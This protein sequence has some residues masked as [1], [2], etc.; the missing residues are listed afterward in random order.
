MRGAESASSRLRSTKSETTSA[1]AATTAS[2]CATSSGSTS[3]RWRSG[4]ASVSRRGMTPSTG[5]F[6]GASARR[7]MASCRVV[8]AR[9]TMRPAIRTSCRQVAKP[10]TRAAID[11]LCRSASTTRITGSP[12]PAARSAVE[13]VP[14]AAPSNR[15]MTPSTSSRSAAAACTAAS[16]ASRAGRM[17]QGSRLTAARPATRP[18]MAV[19][20]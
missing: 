10:C 5:M 12:S 17:A 1:A 11:W 19:S 8:A 4:S 6:V 20:I 16:A 7:S 18:R 3:P 13:P 15:P 14:S 2:N 9:L